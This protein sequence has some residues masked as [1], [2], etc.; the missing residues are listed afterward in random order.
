[1]SSA[2]KDC[3]QNSSVRTELCDDSLSAER[4]KEI[5][6]VCVRHRLMVASGSKVRLWGFCL[7]LRC[8]VGAGILGQKPRSFSREVLS[9]LSLLPKISLTVNS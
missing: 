6:C 4:S 5:S 9:T 1:M 3:D 8:F 7:W 2:K